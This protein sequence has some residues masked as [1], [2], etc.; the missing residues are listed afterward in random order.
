MGRGAKAGILILA[1]AGFGLRVVTPLLVRAATPQCCASMSCCRSGMCSMHGQNHQPMKAGHSCQTPKSTSSS[2]MC[3]LRSEIPAS[4]LVGAPTNFWMQLPTAS[5][6]PK[7][8]PRG[9]HRGSLALEDLAGHT[10]LPDHPPKS[11]A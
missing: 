3:S 7:L 11:Q 4:P 1:L 8:S 6:T 2:C 10:L 5:R 9:Y